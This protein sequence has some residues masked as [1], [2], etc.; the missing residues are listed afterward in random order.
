MA[1]PKTIAMEIVKK[2]ALLRSETAPAPALK[3]DPKSRNNARRSRRLSGE[4]DERRVSKILCIKVLG[5]VKLS[6]HL[7]LLPFFFFDLKTPCQAVYPRII[8]PYGTKYISFQI[9]FVLAIG[10]AMEI[11]CMKSSNTSLVL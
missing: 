6:L 8:Y 2:E 7:L 1:E 10:I 3:E 9:Y 4:R 11:C 5:E